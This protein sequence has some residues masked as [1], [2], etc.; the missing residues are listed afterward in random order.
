MWQIWPFSTRILQYCFIL[1][2]LFGNFKIFWFTVRFEDQIVRPWVD[3]PNCE[4]HGETVRVGRSANVKSKLDL[5]TAVNVPSLTRTKGKMHR[6]KSNDIQAI[7]TV[8]LHSF[9]WIKLGF[10][11]QVIANLFSL[12][13]ISNKRLEQSKNISSFEAIKSN[14]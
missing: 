6:G 10:F 9:R 5:S 14:D 3:T 12:L 8:N 7:K 1:P 4:S 2:E 13:F 11:F